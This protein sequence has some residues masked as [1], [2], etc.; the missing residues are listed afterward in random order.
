ME[1]T[2]QIFAILG[3]LAAVVAA[4]IALF[5]ARELYLWRQELNWDDSLRTAAKLMTD[6]EQSGWIPEVV[7]GLGRSGGIWGGWLAGNLGSLPFGVVDD[8]YPE[9]EFP[10]GSEALEALR[11]T[12]PHKRRMLVVEGASS[13]GE[14]INRFRDKFAKAELEGIELKFAVLY[15]NPASSAEIQY[16]GEVGPEPWP[17]SFPWHSTKRYRSYLRDIFRSAVAPRNPAGSQ[18]SR[19]PTN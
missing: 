13:R 17:D 6:I 2:V 10:G 8:K 3:A 19:P 15:V 1:L 14:T 4:A 9:V 12:Y 16:I 18:A 11:K 7:V 5:Q